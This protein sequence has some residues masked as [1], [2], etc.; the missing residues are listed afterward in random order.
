MSENFTFQNLGNTPLE[1]LIALM[2]RLRDPQTGCPWDKEQT[3]KTIAPYT[4]EEAYE[5]SDA[6]DKNDM[7]ELKEELGD[8]LLQVV[9]HARM[10]EEQGAFDFA[11]ICDTLVRKMISRHPHVFGDAEQRDSATQTQAWAQN[12]ESLKAQE[13]SQKG[14]SS[15]LDGVASALP[16]LMRAEKLQKRAARVGFDWP[17]A[18]LVLAK[19]TEEAAEIAEA[20][21][22][23]EP[24]HRI[25][26]EVGDLLF[27]VTNL[28][29]KLGVDP[30]H[31][32]RDTNRKFTNRFQYI[33]K[34]A[35]QDLSD[36][37]LDD[38]EALWQKAKSKDH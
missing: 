29:R 2:A 1:R 28:A 37:P 34:N 12:W 23:G 38:M 14:T 36:M 17:N 7:G 30:E 8:L 27:A 19:V 25:H 35:D 9:F 5:V 31:A 24:Q 33:E 26:E 10:G 18:D 13:R 21:A 6:I 3:F 4:I 20:Q 22:N 32:L 11:E 16:A 15:V